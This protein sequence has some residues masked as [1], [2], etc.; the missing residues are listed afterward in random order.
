MF[1]RYM[2]NVLVYRGMSLSEAKEAAACEIESYSRKDEY[3]KYIH[4][5]DAAQEA[6][7]YWSD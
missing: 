1:K 3:W 5:H 6:L 7:S 4:P 2:I